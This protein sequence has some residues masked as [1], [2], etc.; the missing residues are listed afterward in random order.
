ML[1]SYDAGDGWPAFLLKL[2]TR[3]ASWQRLGGP[4]DGQVSISLLLPSCIAHWRDN[5]LANML[6]ETMAAAKRSQ[7]VTVDRLSNIIA[8]RSLVRE[9]GV[10][11]R[12]RGTVLR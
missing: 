4:S 6:R 9:E 10:L 7:Y 3:A 1:K 12:P 8:L 11:S 2:A 5:S